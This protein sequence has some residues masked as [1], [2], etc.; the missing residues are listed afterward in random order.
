MDDYNYRD[1]IMSREDP[2]FEDFQNGLHVGHVAP[3]F[4][5]T[6]LHDGQAKNLESYWEAGPCIVEFG[7]FT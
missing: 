1:F 6:D 2:Y 5:L 7:S 4:E 3:D